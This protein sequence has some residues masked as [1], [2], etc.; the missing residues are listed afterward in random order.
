MSATI[1]NAVGGATL[2][3][4]SLPIIS[5][6]PERVSRL[7]GSLNPVITI[8]QVDKVMTYNGD[9]AFRVYGEKKR[10]CSYSGVLEGERLKGFAVSGG[11]AV[12]VKLKHQRLTIKDSELPV[13]DYDFGVWRWVTGGLKNVESVY[14]IARHNCGP[15]WETKTKLRVDNLT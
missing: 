11:K 8:K 3:L 10:E 12:Q 13:G 6:A 2:F 4:L 15:F 14:V 1:V 9:L 5:T 7:D